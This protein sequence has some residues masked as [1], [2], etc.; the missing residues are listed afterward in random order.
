M[1]GYI[2]VSR[3]GG[4][5]GDSYISPS[6]QRDAIQRWADYKG[7]DIDAWHM[8]EDWSGGTQDR[9]A[10]TEAVK[11]SLAGATGGIVCW[12]I[13]RFSRTTEGGLRDLRRLEAAN[14]RLAFVTE[15]IDTGSTMGKMIYTML[16]AMSEAFL[17][18]IKASWLES[19]RRAIARGV[20]ASRTPWWAVRN[21]DGTLAPHPV[22][23]K[24]ALK[25]FELASGGN[26]QAPLAY[27]QRVA[28][29]RTWNTTKVR[30]LLAQRTVLGEVR[31]GDFLNTETLG[32]LVSVAVW[33][34]AQGTP[35]RRGASAAYPLSG[36]ALCA[37][38]GR[39]LVGNRGG[40]RVKV[41]TYRCS[42]SLTAVVER[43]N[44][45]PTITADILEH[46]VRDA[47]RSVMPV[48]VIIGRPASDGFAAAEQRLAEASAELE[49]FSSDLTARR[50]LGADYPRLQQLRIDERND[51]RE[52]Y[53]REVAKGAATPIE[54]T[55]DKLLTD[56][57]LFR[58][59][60]GSL[61]ETIR[62]HR[63]RRPVAERVELVPA[64]LDGAAR[65][66]GGESGE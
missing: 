64:E 31:N 42:G 40:S 54:Y 51:A 62:V 18:N 13:D 21:P 33:E 52:E 10:L 47:I 2:R 34:A 17:E 4:R 35:A 24:H 36:L 46:H 53:R 57:D 6:V 9:P 45:G 1:D 43:C 30:R 23:A 7:I 50:E 49:A 5:E 28:P 48:R 26:V 55:P 41:R 63:G 16:L 3:V 66:P 12:K 20:H 56:N 19:K 8:D 25:A 38:C 59:L 44:A 11:R 22:N 15:D 39:H 37:A 14:A 60:S 27:L 61:F 65:M 29:E 58:M 32:P